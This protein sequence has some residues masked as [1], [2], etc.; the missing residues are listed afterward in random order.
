MPIFFSSDQLHK[1]LFTKL[2][3]TSSFP[4]DF[5]SKKPFFTNVTKSLICSL[6]WLSLTRFLLLKSLNYGVLPV[7]FKGEMNLEIGSFFELIHRTD[8][9]QN[10]VN[11]VGKHL[12]LASFAN[13]RQNTDFVVLS[14][15]KQDLCCKIFKV[16]DHFTTLRSKGLIQFC[17]WSP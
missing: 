11:C 14:F 5:W 8:I 1:I 9:L 17:W 16:C 10:F 4:R 7:T 2:Q 12:P 15:I 6:T 3:I 13:V